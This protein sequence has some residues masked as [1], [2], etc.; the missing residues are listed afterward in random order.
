MT[1]DAATETAR[2]V[3]SLKRIMKSRGVTYAQLARDIGLSEPSIKRILS[4]ATL[5]LQLLE[6][7]CGALDVIEDEE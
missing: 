3:A 4:R 7:I 6:Q 2:I 5:T 1:A